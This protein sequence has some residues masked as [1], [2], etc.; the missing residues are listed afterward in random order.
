MHKGCGLQY[1]VYHHFSFALI[2][3]L[4]AFDS[5]GFENIPHFS[6]LL[7]ALQLISKTLGK[8]RESVQHILQFIE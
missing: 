6:N 5:G 7:K 3:V 1:T 8:N 2:Q 4:D